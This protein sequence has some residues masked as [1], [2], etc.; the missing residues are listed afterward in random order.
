MLCLS[1]KT[2]SLLLLGSKKMNIPSSLF[3]SKLHNEMRFRT[4]SS[5]EDSPVD[6]GRNRFNTKIGKI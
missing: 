6:I 1:M 4:F 2:T 3:R 5:K